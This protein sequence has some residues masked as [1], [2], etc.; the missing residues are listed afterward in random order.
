MIKQRHLI[1]VSAVSMA[2]ALAGGAHA[3]DTA[4]ED[5]QV[6]LNE[7][8]VTAQKRSENAQDVPI[9]ITAFSGETI[10]ERGISDVSALGNSTPSVTLDAGT[11]FAGSGAALGASIRGIGQN[12]FSIA[13]D[14]GVGIY[15]DGVYL[16]RT[17]GAN[18][19]LPD[20]ER[21]EILK[22]PQGTLFGRN[23]IGGAI[24]IVTHEP[25]EEFSLKGS[26][27]L[28]QFGRFDLAA[29]ADVPV[30][31]RLRSSLT[32]SS[33]K[34]DGFVKRVA[35]TR[36][37][38]FV[39]EA[40]S[41]FRETGYAS[42]DREGGIN[43]WSIRGKLVWTPASNIKVTV[44]GDYY[45]SDSSGLPNVVLD[46]LDTFPG[47]F[48]GTGFTPVPGSALTPGT[49]FNFAGLYNFCI[50][51]T[52]AQI[53]ARNAQSLCGPRGSEIEPSRILPGLGAANVD[54]DPLNDRLP[55]DDRWVST[56]W[57]R[58]YA[59]GNSFARTKNW[60]F[61][62][63]LDW[64]LSEDV[65]VRSITGYRELTW[66]SG[67]DGDNSPIN[68]LHVSNSAKQKQ[69]SQELQLVGSTESLG[70]K[71]NYV[72]GGYYFNETAAANDFVTIGGGLTQIE[73]PIDVKNKNFAFFGQ[74]DWR[75]SDLIGITL[76][77][78][79]T[80][81]TKDFDAR[82]TDHAGF[83]YDLFNCPVSVP[84]CPGILGFPVAGQPLRVYPANTPSRKFTNFAPKL[85][86][87][88]HPAEDLMV[89]GSYTQGYKV[90]GWSTRLQNPIPTAKTF[91]EEEAKTYEFGIKSSFLNNRIRANLALF[92][93]DYSNIQLLFQRG[94][95]PV[96][97]NAGD[98][99]I[100]GA[101]LD[102]QAS[103][104]NHFTL[105]L[106][107]GW[108][109]SKLKNVIG[110]TL[111][112]S[113]QEGT[114]NGAPLP[115]VP[116]FTFNISP[117]FELP[118]GDQSKL[119]LL[120]DYTH[121]SSMWN[122]AQR[123]YLLRRPTTDIINASITFK[124]EQGWSLAVGGTNIT[125]KRYIVNGLGQKSGGLVYAIPNRPSEWYVRFGFEF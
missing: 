89:Y 85:G 53:S 19:T 108:L 83:N 115:K 75:I 47:S 81:E 45:K 121:S 101:E 62:G 6:G 17:V 71:L 70:G 68:Y 119:I 112:D 72:L 105:T 5:N 43:D 37:T 87:Q 48:A 110:G 49:G 56:D 16:A 65:L 18:V 15:L 82:Q 14:P 51:S 113:V 123:T 33:N 36:A 11:P 90:G 27:T 59:T 111:P 118:L 88:F 66:S 30:S 42:S 98:G 120:A 41:L 103:I 38:P 93:T 80:E 3:Q 122:D 46:V 74:V 32:F 76:G 84:A 24:N 34:R 20:V 107:A 4:A 125:N 55:F 25:G 69:F 94:T 86:V 100:K 9:A 99:R 29:T 95:N 8:I 104:T 7:I 31:E 39:Q 40:N 63:I 21:V 54:A 22:G 92:Q 60:G 23:T 109:D 35:Y 73:G 77:G 97:E 116:D 67:F 26:A 64:D 1:T 96:I 10:K 58:S 78:R 12:D 79:Y 13:V 61:S 106:A 50:N 28:G 2:L 124:Q 52:L 114:N 91:D 44:A 102:I 117:R 57:N